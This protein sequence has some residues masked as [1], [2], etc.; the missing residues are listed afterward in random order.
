VCSTCVGYMCAVHVWSTCVKYMCGVNVSEDMCGVPSRHVF[1][2]WIASRQKTFGKC[3][4]YISCASLRT[5]MCAVHV[6]STAHSERW[7][8]GVEYHFQEI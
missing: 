2:L 8:A 5:H 4:Q 3:V 1:R 6:C 7:G